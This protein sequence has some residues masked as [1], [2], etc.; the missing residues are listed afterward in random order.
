MVHTEALE[1]L[2]QLQR[3]GVRPGL[4]R[5]DA[6]LTLLEHP[7][8]QFQSV[9]IAGTNGKGSTAAMVASALIQGRSTVGLYTSPH[10][11][12]F[13]ERIVVS[14]VPISHEEIVQLT[15]H[16]REKIKFR[17][18][19][20]LEEISFFE[21]TTAMAF[22]FFFEKK[23]DLAV[24]EVGMGGRFDA[25][26]LLSPLVTGITHIG[27]DHQQYLGTTLEEII[28]EKAGIIKE[29]TPIVT[30]VSQ[31]ELLTV[32][33]KKARE[34][35][36]P[37]IRLGH[38]ITLS[39]TDPAQPIRFNAPSRFDYDGLKERRVECG[40][41]GRHQIDNAA[42]AIGLLEQLGLRGVPLSEQDLLEGIRQVSWKG[43]L[44]ILQEQPLFLLDGAHNPSSAKRLGEF[45][46][47]VDPD[48]SGKHWMLI[49]MMSDKNIPEV[50]SPLIGWTDAFIFSRPEI[51]RAADPNE[52]MDSVLC[53]SKETSSREG[54]PSC[55][56]R[57]KV[58]DALTY[59]KAFIRPEDTL[60]ITGSF[61]T[62]GEAK[63]LLTGTSPSLIRG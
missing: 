60:V 26:N 59:I 31:P 14:G 53:V 28:A 30:S 27:L 36:A 45:L 21:F 29:S 41:L 61:Y 42:V 32:L 10:L 54:F 6:L 12:D 48:R 16:I 40:L 35:N 15:E 37:L 49:G 5:M 13:S 63:A 58:F 62:V 52:I 47:R 24:V 20:L 50:L 2:Y 1:Y 46:S 38:E 57:E 43:R 39:I 23:V 25:T 3:H 8:H 55:T 11:I 33:E 51:K 56:V 18:P 44:E 4:E 22:L 34:R 9:H 7:E 17:V 19:R